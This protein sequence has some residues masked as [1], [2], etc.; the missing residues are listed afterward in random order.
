[1]RSLLLSVLLLCT[2]Y[3]V[4]GAPSHFDTITFGDTASEAAHH[5]KR[6]GTVQTETLHT[7][8]GARTTDYPV[9]TISKQGSAVSCELSL[10]PEGKPV[11]LEIQEIHNRHPEV[12]GYTVLV[13]DKAVYFRTY[14]E[15]TAGPNH[16]FVVIDPTV[17]GRAKTFRVTL[18]NESNAA[19]SIRQMWAYA[20]FFDGLARDEAVY[21]PLPVLFNP[22][23][24]FTD[25]RDRNTVNS[26]DLT[27]AL[28]K[29]REFEG[30]YKDLIS[31]PPGVLWTGGFN[32]GNHEPS[33]VM[34][35]MDKWLTIASEMKRP[36]QMDFNGAWWG[37]GPGGADGLGGYFSDLKYYQVI[38][39]ADT[40]TYHSVFGGSFNPCTFNNAQQLK[41]RCA[42][43]DVIIHHLVDKIAFMKAQGKW[44]PPLEIIRCSGE[45]YDIGGDFS[46][47]VRAT[48]KA[49]GVELNPED[50]LDA[51]ELDWIDRNLVRY[52]TV[53]AKNTADGV[54]RDAVL[55]DRGAMQL[56]EKQLF[57]DLFLE[58]GSGNWYPH[59]DNERR[60][61][62]WRSFNT[63]MWPCNEPGGG[64]VVSQRCRD[65]YVK[66]IGKLG[67][68]NQE[69]GPGNTNL[70]FLINHYQ[71]GYQ[72][73]TFHGGN[74]NSHEVIRRIDQRDDQPARAPVHVERRLLDVD[75]RRDQTMGPKS[76]IVEV[77]NLAH[78]YLKD[79]G[80]MA[81][82]IKAERFQEG[83]IVYRVE[84]RDGDFAHDLMLALEARIG[85]NEH[86][87][88]YGGNTADALQPMGTL[89]A[90]DLVS[91]KAFS[92]WGTQW[93]TV[94]LGEAM[95]KCDL[96]PSTVFFLKIVLPAGGGQ[97]FAN[98]VKVT[99]RWP[100]AS[101]Q[102]DGSTPT[103]KQARILQLWVQDRAV[104][105][106]LLGR[107][108]QL[109]GNDTTS[110]NA[111]QLIATGR[112]RTAYRLLAGDIS[113]ALPA[114]YAVRGHGTL[115]RYPITLTL[116][117][118]D[119]VAL[120]TVQKA[121]K[122]GVAFSLK[123][124]VEQPCHLEFTRLRANTSY[125]LNRE[126]INQY[127][128]QPAQDKGG[129]LADK[130]GVAAVD[131]ALT[132]AEAPIPLPKTFS[133]MCLGGSDKS[134]RVWLQDPVLALANQSIV[135]PVAPGATATR[136]LDGSQE[137]PVKA[138][139][140]ELDCVDVT[141]DDKGNAT[142]ILATYGT[143]A[144]RIKKF[145][146]PVLHGG[147]VSNG[148]IELENGHRYELGYSYGFTRFNTL[149]LS[150][151]YH[152]PDYL[153]ER[154]KSGSYVEIA[155]CPLRAGN[156]LPRATVVTQ[157]V[158]S[159]L[160]VTF[161]KDDPAWR[162]TAAG[163]ENLDMRMS[164]KDQ[165]LAPK[166]SGGHQGMGE[167]G[168]IDYEITADAPLEEARLDYTCKISTPPEAPLIFFVSDDGKQWTK[169]GQQALNLDRGFDLAIPR[170][171][172]ISPSIKGKQHFF[173]RVSMSMRVGVSG[174]G[175]GK[176]AI[177]GVKQ[178]R[179]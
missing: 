75:T 10:Q 74:P 80:V 19:F 102:A 44:I 86:V 153:A 167:A 111:E 146:P 138:W 125:V 89:T 81:Y 107:Y 23:V 133:A 59:W 26:T 29:I 113:Q 154:I 99:R 108:R 150:H 39:R 175:I 145:E 109:C 91:E 63:A 142:R 46:D 176:L 164:D 170:Q 85:Q 104:T 3:A 68:P 12:F 47:A 123:T 77:K 151:P 2:A 50:G 160:N 135:V 117:N 37:G 93:G 98:S 116:S 147:P 90:A 124:E 134:I 159:L 71:A 140:R 177:S 95:E 121:D 157:P 161:S 114:R 169:C 76:Q 30:H 155:Y 33:G 103:I 35:Y 92:P 127:T 18:R 40:K 131:L 162:Q 64:Y 72:F 57:D 13:N 8:I 178:Q 144:G 16:Y 148:V 126:G 82:L 122:D 149:L 136:Q 52:L 168:T 118:D 129:I 65:D 143:D 5:V 78:S 130:N 137:A 152:D 100:W 7:V 120:C 14:Y 112:Y 41:A 84:S 38:Y 141:L 156:I 119:A 67:C 88:I 70:S 24:Q 60:S 6:S 31:Y 179:P 58:A 27:A 32:Y 110:R 79:A 163:C 173:L 172:D 73:E 34:Q 54:G 101:G 21:R 66:A 51:A 87:D 25:D 174:V 4:W 17:I 105:L 55:I 43:F 20:N 83:S 9:R 62:F 139:P 53:L 94:N 158:T 45:D 166:A 48:A 165:I 97:P 28:Q 132:T 36:T 106:R 115:G 56:P 61:S 42:R 15:M 1:M 128:L 22:N 11:V 69:I 96:A 49:D 171:L